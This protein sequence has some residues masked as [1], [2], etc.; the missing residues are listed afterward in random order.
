[1][2]LYTVHPGVG[3]GNGPVRPI[4]ADPGYDCGSHSDATF[5]PGTPDARYV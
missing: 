5:V 1:V 2:L 4:D 3:S